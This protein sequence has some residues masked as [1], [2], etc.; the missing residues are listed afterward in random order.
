MGNETELF[1]LGQT[2]LYR[3]FQAEKDEILRHKWLES[4]KVGYDIGFEWALVDWTTRHRAAWQRSRHMNPA[5]Q[6]A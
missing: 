3:E 6:S 5:W 4:E 1:P 2:T